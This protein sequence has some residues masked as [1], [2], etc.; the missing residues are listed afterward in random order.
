[1]STLSTA[2][3]QTGSVESSGKESTTAPAPRPGMHLRAYPAMFTAAL[4]LAL[5]TAN[6]CQGIAHL[7]S[8]MY[9]LVLWGWWGCVGSVLWKLG[10]RTPATV[11]FTAK[12]ISVNLFIGITLG[13]VH[14]LLLGSPLAGW[15]IHGAPGSRW[16]ALLNINRFGIEILIYGFV[17]GIT[18]I[19]QYQIRAQREAMKSLELQR[20]LSAAQLRALQMQLEPHFLFNTLNAI[21][22]PLCK[23]PSQKRTIRR[24]SAT[25][26]STFALRTE[27]TA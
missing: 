4:I 21:T 2:I 3:R 5:V 15:A 17:F 27:N 13:V 12:A 1:M 10:Q 14:L 11:G 16:N 25:S 7:P 22:T 20:Q 9:G 18:G 8:L 24:N 23:P 6:E 26:G 19:V